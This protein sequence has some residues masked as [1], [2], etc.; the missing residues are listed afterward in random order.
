MEKEIK[1]Q[2]CAIGEEIDEYLD[3]TICGA[4]E[5]LEDVTIPGDGKYIVHEPEQVAEDDICKEFTK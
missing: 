5:E 2:A 4:T 1:K 3:G